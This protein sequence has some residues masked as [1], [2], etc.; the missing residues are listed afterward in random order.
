MGTYAGL[1]FSGDR[2][3]PE[4]LTRILGTEPRTAYRKGDVFKI[5]RGHEVRGRTGLWLLSS[6]GR[7]DSLDLNDHLDYLLGL[8]FPDGRTDKLPKL[9]KLMRNFQIEA[10]VPCFWHGEHGAEPPVVRDDIRSQ[11]ARIPAAIEE[12]FD[13][14]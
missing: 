4:S 14:D 10:D 8:V 6:E 12:D 5:V 1:R 13:T 3:A 9:Q 2:L 7:V 11:F